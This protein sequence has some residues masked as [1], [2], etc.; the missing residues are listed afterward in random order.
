LAEVKARWAEASP[1]PWKQG[2]NWRRVAAVTN[3]VIAEILQ[4][5]LGLVQEQKNATALRNAAQDVAWL[6]SEVERLTDAHSLYQP[7]WEES[8]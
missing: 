3:H 7:V 8:Y 5:Q 6:I 2:A 1:P 4:S